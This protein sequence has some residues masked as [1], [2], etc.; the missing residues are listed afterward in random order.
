MAL[1]I[2]LD[3]RQK[4]KQ[5][6]RIKN[7]AFKITSEYKHVQEKRRIESYQNS[8]QSINQ[9]IDRRSILWHQV[10]IFCSFNVSSSLPRSTPPQISC[11][12]YHLCPGTAAKTSMFARTL[13]WSRTKPRETVAEES[14]WCLARHDGTAV[15]TRN[16]RQSPTVVFL[17][18]LNHD[19]EKISIFG[20]VRNQISRI[21]TAHPHGR[22]YCTVF[23]DNTD[24]CRSNWAWCTVRW[25]SFPPKINTLSTASK[26]E[27][28][29]YKSEEKRSILSSRT[30][31]KTLKKTSNFLKK[32]QSKKEFQLQ[33]LA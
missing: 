11:V 31:S 6:D 23:H 18:F 20:K 1:V 29:L 32:N 2:F 19:K 12:F 17:P 28:F 24:D 13:P 10:S 30:R 8:D 25:N 4:T 27:S 15:L 33:S 22:Q 7:K 9:S 26:M 5:I 14:T 3:L 16:A 21:S